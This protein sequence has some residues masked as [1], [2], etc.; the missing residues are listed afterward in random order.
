MSARDAKHLVFLARS[1][2]D[3]DAAKECVEELREMGVNVVFCRCD[4]SNLDS[5]GIAMA[6]C[7]ADMLLVRNVTQA[8]MILRVS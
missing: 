1:G 4:V 2:T 5:L 6:K 8:S 3:R 7:K